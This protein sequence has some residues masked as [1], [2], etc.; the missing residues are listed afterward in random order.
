MRNDRLF[1]GLE[2]DCK[3]GTPG[4]A[5]RAAK[6]SRALITDTAP[7]TAAGTNSIETVP[8]IW[9]YI[10]LSD[11]CSIS[12]LSIFPDLGMCPTEIPAK[13]CSRK[14]GRDATQQAR[15]RI[16]GALPLR[17]ADGPAG[18][19]AH[20][21]AVRPVELALSRVQVRR[22]QHRRLSVCGGRPYHVQERRA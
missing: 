7:Y 5:L 11:T 10:S 12:T 1:S 17:G 4:D 13:R 16:C 3:R 14:A 19:N 15:E 6:A 8:A 20:P 2:A 9:H 22:L 18:S 21:L